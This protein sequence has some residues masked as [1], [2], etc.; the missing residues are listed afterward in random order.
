M[1]SSEAEESIID[2]LNNLT[3]SDVASATEFIYDRSRIEEPEFS[4]N[5]GND[6]YGLGGSDGITFNG[7]SSLNDQHSIRNAHMLKKKK[8]K[9][10]YDSSEAKKSDIVDSHI[11]SVKK[12]S[13]K[14]VQVA[15]EVTGQQRVQV[16]AGYEN[17]EIPCLQ[18]GCSGVLLKWVLT[19]FGTDS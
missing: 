12:D 11:P 14:K 1:D 5:S 19:F 2:D 16:N 18:Q 10:S 6:E 7:H 15:T 9:A 4:G 17:P 8:F 13:T 3:E